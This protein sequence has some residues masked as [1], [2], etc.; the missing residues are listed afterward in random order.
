M[1]KRITDLLIDIIYKAHSYLLTLNDSYET[2]LS[3]KELHFLIIGIMGVLM[4]MVFYP[5]FK[6][7]AKKHLEILIAWFYVFTILVVITFAIEI[8]QWY[9]NSGVMEFRDIVAGL[10]GYFLMSFIFMAIVGIVDLIRKK[11]SYNS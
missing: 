1:I 11:K 7:L 9:S 3:D 4:L 6:C 5:L 8:A 2:Y 10:A